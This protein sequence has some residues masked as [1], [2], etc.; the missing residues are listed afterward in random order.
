MQIVPQEVRTGVPTVS[1]EDCKEGAFGPSITL[2]LRWLLHIEHNR[3]SVFVVVTN[4]ALI[5]VCCVGLHHAVLLDRVLGRLEV[6]KR[7]VGELQGLSRRTVWPVK[8][9]HVADVLRD[10]IAFS[11][12]QDWDLVSRCRSML[13]PRAVSSGLL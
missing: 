9:L 4:D 1:I 11:I 10:W 8:K 6:W 2:L 3:N 5:G 12:S 7:D 13:V